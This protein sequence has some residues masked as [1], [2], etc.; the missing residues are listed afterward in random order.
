MTDR[1]APQRSVPIRPSCVKVRNDVYPVDQLS[2]VR[3]VMHKPP[4]DPMLQAEAAQGARALQVAD[5]R[6]ADLERRLTDA[7]AGSF[8]SSGYY[9]P[10]K[11]VTLPSSDV[12]NSHLLTD[13]WQACCR[14]SSSERRQLCGCRGGSSPRL[15][16][17]SRGRCAACTARRD[18]GAACRTRPAAAA[19]G[20]VKLGR[21]MTYPHR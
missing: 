8:C 5:S 18:P 20:Q 1:A 6:I 12:I 11:L 21:A 17:G 7:M 13:R 15:P 16:R 4:C 14:V 10:F 3:I 19:A 9:A 2:G